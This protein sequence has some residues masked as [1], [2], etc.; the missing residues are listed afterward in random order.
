MWWLLFVKIVL[1]SSSSPLGL[2]LPLFFI[3]GGRGYKEG[4]RVGYN[5]I[6]IRTLS[7]LA[8]FTHI[9]IYIYN[10]LLLGEHVMVLW[11]LLDG[12]SSYS[13]PLLRPFESMRGGTPSTNH[14]QYPSSLCSG[15]F[16]IQ[17]CHLDFKGAYNGVCILNSGVMLKCTLLTW[18]SRWGEMRDWSLT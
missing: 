4:N 15:H 13:R 14:H 1:T 6:P 11:N 18:L 16:V 3:Q 10:Y 9:Y 17:K 12:E 2:P 8:Y 7:L 5:M